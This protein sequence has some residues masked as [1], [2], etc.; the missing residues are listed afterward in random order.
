MKWNAVLSI[1]AVDEPVADPL[2]LGVVEASVEPTADL[3]PCVVDCKK[4]IFVK[5]WQS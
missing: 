1:D 3:N 4:Q 5:G 2:V